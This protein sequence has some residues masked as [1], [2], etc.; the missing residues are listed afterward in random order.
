MGNKLHSSWVTAHIS[1]GSGLGLV[2]R[3]PLSTRLLSS[4]TGHSCTGDY[5]APAPG[6]WRRKR[7]RTQG[8]PW[9]YCE[10]EISL[11]YTETLYQKQNKTKLNRKDMHRL[12]VDTV[13]F[14]KGLEHSRC[15]CLRGFGTNLPRTSRDKIVQ[16]LNAHAWVHPPIY[17]PIHACIYLDLLKMEF[18]VS[19]MLNKPA[20]TE[21]YLQL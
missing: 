1:Q 6:R 13:W 12:S 21:L 19:Y 9:Q 5:K 20:T 14:Y 17:P 11:G 16:Y 8:H 4:D 15:L 2:L 7:P 3:S 10:L 18:M